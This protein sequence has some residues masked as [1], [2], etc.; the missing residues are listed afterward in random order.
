MWNDARRAGQKAVAK[1]LKG[2]RYALWKNPTDLTER[3][4]VKL[5]DIRRTNEQLYRA[6]LMKEQL[7]MVLHQPTYAQALDTLAEWLAWACRSRIPAFVKLSRKIRRHRTGIQAALVNEL[8]SAR[9]ESGEHQDPA[10]HPPRVRVPLPRSAHRAGH[11]LPRRVLPTPAR[12]SLTTGPDQPE[13]AN[14]RPD[15]N[16]RPASGEA[17]VEDQR[18]TCSRRRARQV[19]SPAHLSA[20]SA[21]DLWTPQIQQS[22]ITSPAVCRPLPWTSLTPPTDMCQDPKNSSVSMPR[23]TAASRYVL[24]ML[25]TVRRHRA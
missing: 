25:E 16:Q 24:S 9:V 17:A 7:W 13:H 12:P 20:A 3:Q 5:S 8:S 15:R 10:D 2:A 11:A 18:R 23:H 22:V 4:Q 19:T 14:G 1:D 6:Y 21:A